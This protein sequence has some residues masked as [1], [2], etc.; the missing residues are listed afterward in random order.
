ALVR[1]STHR[2]CPSI[3]KGFPHENACPGPTYQVSRRWSQTARQPPAKRSKWVRL[4]SASL[5][6]GSRL[7][8]AFFISA[9]CRVNLSASA[10]RAV[11]I[12]LRHDKFESGVL[13]IRP[14]V[15]RVHMPDTKESRRCAPYEKE[16]DHVSLVAV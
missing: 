4:P 13:A 1:T 11:L 9:S 6:K 12:P 16:F 7:S 3:E 15:R 2:A 8:G 14:R 10:S 5:K